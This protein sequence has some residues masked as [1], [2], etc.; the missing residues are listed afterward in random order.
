MWLCK[1]QTSWLYGAREPSISAR[2]ER[3]RTGRRGEWRT[4]KPPPWDAFYPPTSCLRTYRWRTEGLSGPCS[5]FSLCACVKSIL[6]SPRGP[7]WA[8][9]PG[10]LRAQYKMT[11]VR[12]YRKYVEHKGV[13][14]SHNFTASC[15]M[16]QVQ[17]F[18]LFLCLSCITS[19]TA[20]LA[21]TCRKAWVC[22]SIKYS[23]TK[24]R[25]EKMGL[26]LF[27]LLSHN[28]LNVKI[29]SIPYPAYFFHWRVIC[30]EKNKFIY[31][32]QQK[33]WDQ[34]QQR[35]KIQ[36]VNINVCITA[37][38]KEEKKICFQHQNLFFYTKTHSLWFF[39]QLIWS[40]LVWNEL[41]LLRWLMLANPW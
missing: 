30:E 18:I 10:L 29:K 23:A 1:R 39:D 20:V 27:C 24:F 32:S 9:T 26:R 15:L 13:T 6:A 41:C 38:K 2:A 8:P 34:L 5:V 35:V 3:V 12:T 7:Q 4:W 17:P 22:V 11:K 25:F 28:T 14:L 31:K 40:S 19:I 36:V 37:V 16:W 21:T 33:L